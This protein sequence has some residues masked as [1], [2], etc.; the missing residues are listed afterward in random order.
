L[1]ERLR[2]TMTEMLGQAREEVISGK[3]LFGGSAPS[4]VTHPL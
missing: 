2:L 4:A 1:T 3:K